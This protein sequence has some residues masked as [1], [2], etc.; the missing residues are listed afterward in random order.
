M[1]I[2][3]RSHELSVEKLKSEVPTTIFRPSVVV[4]D[5]QTGETAKYDGI[6]YLIHYLRKAP[7]LLRLLN[8]GNKKVQLNLV[9]V[10]FVVDGIAA[11][12]DDEA[13]IGK[14]IALAD[15]RPLA[16]ADIFD[17]ITKELCSKGSALVLPESLTERM[18]MLPFSPPISGLPHSAVPYFF[19]PQT[20]DTA[21]ADE[22]LAKHGIKCPP[23]SN[24]VSKLL[25][26][27]DEHPKL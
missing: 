23:F 17:G 5:S 2:K 15:P 13:A 7:S 21:V 14:T 26:F 11:L 27:V 22:L 10:D 4:G 3:K 9:P 19:L 20:Y 25:D 6:Y 1:G 8:V 12:S 24:Y 18:L 16:T